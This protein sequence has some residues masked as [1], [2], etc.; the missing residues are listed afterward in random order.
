MERE[1]RD[2][3][4]RNWKGTRGRGLI[5]EFL[6]EFRAMYNYH[7]KAEFPEK[8]NTKKDW[9]EQKSITTLIQVFKKP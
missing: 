3:K 9:P 2:E 6:G 1:V 8:L 4:A 5:V 7:S